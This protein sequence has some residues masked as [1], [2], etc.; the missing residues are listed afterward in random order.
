M[1]FKNKQCILLLSFS[2]FIFGI[3][4][5]RKYSTL[6]EGYDDES[7]LP[8]LIDTVSSDVGS[9]LNLIGVN[10]D[11]ES[12]IFGSN[13]DN[14]EDRVIS[15]DID[16]PLWSPEKNTEPKYIKKTIPKIPD[17][18]FYMTDSCNKKSIVTSDYKDDFCKSDDLAVIENKC[19]SLSKETCNIPTCCILING[20]RCI[21][22]DVKGPSFFTDHDFFYYRNKCYPEGGCDKPTGDYIK[23]CG[24]YA[25][26]STNISKECVIQLFNDAGCSNKSPDALINDDTVYEYSSY[27][28][29]D[30]KSLITNAVNTIKDKIKQGDDDSRMLCYGVDKNKV[31][32]E[33]TNDSLNVSKECMIEM[34]NEAGCSKTTYFTDEIVASLKLRMKE[35]VKSDIYSVANNF[36][37]TNNIMCN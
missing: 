26:N 34:F 36:K 15:I 4:W 13:I 27:E 21:A 7:E 6:I 31:C 1:F 32:D 2:I 9:G 29:Q 20:T 23:N 35:D 22:G 17:I 3:F 28:K 8:E 16:N 11:I 30:I 18:S 25:E 33:Y 24:K 14:P 5:W 12:A 37:A 10:T 19:S